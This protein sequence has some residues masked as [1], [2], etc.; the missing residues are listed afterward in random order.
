M[1]ETCPDCGPNM[2]LWRT[3]RVAKQAMIARPRSC[4]AR[5]GPTAGRLLQH[6]AACA[7]SIGSFF[8]W[9]MCRP[10]SVP[11]FRSISPRRNRRR[12]TSAWSSPRPAS[13]RWRGRFPAAPWWI[14]PVPN[15]LAVAAISVSAL[16]YAAWPIFPVVLRVRVQPFQKR[17]NF[18][19]RNGR[20]PALLMFQ[21]G[22]AC[23]ERERQW[24]IARDF[25]G[26]FRRQ[27]SVLLPKLPVLFP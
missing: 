14:S 12:S 5:K 15:G 18:I 7:A 25:L 4:P 2:A 26:T 27:L 23:N 3:G 10:V 22:T 8:S 20:L 21:T 1:S 6:A 16:A 24:N 17:R 11:S 9:P 13:S 19:R